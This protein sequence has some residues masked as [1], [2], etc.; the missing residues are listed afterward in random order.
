MRKSNGFLARKQIMFQKNLCYICMSPRHKADYIWK[1]CNGSHHIL[2]CQKGLLKS[3]GGNNS[4]AGNNSTI[5]KLTLPATNH[6]QT[7][8]IP[9][10][11]QQNQNNQTV[12]NPDRKY[13]QKLQTAKA[14]VF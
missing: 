2:I 3:T 12:I 5:V 1:M 14:E 6:H 11:Y 9:N 10:S 4:G 7:Q 8:T 13:L